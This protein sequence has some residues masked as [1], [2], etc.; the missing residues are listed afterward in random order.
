MCQKENPVYELSIKVVFNYITQTERFFLPYIYNTI[1]PV[2]SLPNVSIF[3]L[4]SCV[5]HLES[6]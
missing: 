5:W 1:K 3:S 4:E 2:L 6:E